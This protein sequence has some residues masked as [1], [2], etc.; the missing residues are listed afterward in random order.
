MR[1]SARETKR[2]QVLSSS[3][4]R[5]SSFRDID[6]RLRRLSVRNRGDH[7]V[8]CRI[9]GGHRIAILDPHIDARAIAGWP[10]SMREVADRN[11]RDLRE[12]VSSKRLHLIQ[13]PDRD[14]GELPAR[15]AHEI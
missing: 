13:P 14:I 7:S 6:Q 8:R 2:L 15:R 5:G 3:G 12:I 10:Y 1:G 4:L 9:D 11:G